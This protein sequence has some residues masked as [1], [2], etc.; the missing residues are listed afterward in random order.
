M[1]LP[2][3]KF[4]RLWHVG[5]LDPLEKRVGSFEG[6]CLSVSTCPAAWR[7]IARG[8][9][10][11]DCYAADTSQIRFLDAHRLD[12]DTKNIIL[13]WGVKEA[14]AELSSI[15]TVSYYDEE[16][17]DEIF[18]QLDDQ[19]R[20]RQEAAEILD[21]DEDDPCYEQKIASSIAF[22]NEHKGL[23]LLHERAGQ[24]LP[25]YGDINVLDLLLP[26]WVESETDLAG[27]W[28]EDRFNP[29]TYSAPRGGIIPSRLSQIEFHLSA[30]EPYYPD[31]EEQVAA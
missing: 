24:N 29:E 4:D 3:L 20:A 5:S 12:Q 13:S 7:K 6:S 11:G 31:E 28:W 9:V 1:S 27:V 22:S 2:T 21:I 17:E 8:H 26:L 25:I 14:L 19:D 15:W 18:F 10:G 23:P 16:L 30:S